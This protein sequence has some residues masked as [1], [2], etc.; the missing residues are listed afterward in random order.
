MPW[1]R[2]TGLAVPDGPDGLAEHDESCRSMTSLTVPGV[3]IP[4]VH[5][6]V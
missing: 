4:D 1:D 3:T 6:C 2:L 5:D